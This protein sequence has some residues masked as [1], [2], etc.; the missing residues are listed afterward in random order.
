MDGTKVTCISA[1]R[2]NSSCGRSKNNV[3]ATHLRHNSPDQRISTFGL[4]IYN[5]AMKGGESM[6]V[7]LWRSYYGGHVEFK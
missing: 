5:S 4:L 6:E 1:E 2:L 7:I 3:D